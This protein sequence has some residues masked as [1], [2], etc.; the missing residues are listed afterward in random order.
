LTPDLPTFFQCFRVKNGRRD[1][2]RP[3]FTICRAI[4]KEFFSAREER[5]TPKYAFLSM[6][7]DER[8]KGK[9]N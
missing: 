6:Q 7:K 5:L 2:A 4:A 9:Q 8:Q 3:A 1:Y